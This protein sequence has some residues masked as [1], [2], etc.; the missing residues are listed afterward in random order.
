MNSFKWGGWSVL[1]LLFCWS[2][3]RSR[4]KK[5]CSATLKI[6]NEKIPNYLAAAGSAWAVSAIRLVPAR[7]RQPARPP[8]ARANIHLKC[9]KHHQ[10]IKNEPQH[11]IFIIKQTWGCYKTV[12]GGPLVISD[13][14]G[15]AYKSFL[16]LVLGLLQSNGQWLSTK[17]SKC[18]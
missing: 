1:N 3:S 12:H 16:E 13:S 11:I 9:L 2:W 4:Y 17:V 18:L 10:L 8:T 5:T 15:N 7:A 6:T 14:M